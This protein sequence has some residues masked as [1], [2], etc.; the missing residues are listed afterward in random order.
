MSL[1]IRIIQYFRL[2]KILKRLLKQAKD[3]YNF[4]NSDEFWLIIDRDDWESI[5]KISFD[6]LAKECEAEA[7]FFLALS[8][9]C[10]ELWLLL[11]RKKI[12]SFS[13]Q[14]QDSIFRNPRI[15][16]NWNEVPGGNRTYLEKILSNEC[17]GY[18]KKRVR[19]SDFIPHIAIAISNAEELHADKFE[20]YPS[21]CGTHVYLLVKKLIK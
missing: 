3:D 10:F 16:E 21:Q 14:E 19:T 6:E 2:S 12:S 4:K 20:K 8:N 13:D 15:D 9:P 1:T 17:N 18:S 5:H 7:N 11:H